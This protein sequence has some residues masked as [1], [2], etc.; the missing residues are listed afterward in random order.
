MFLHLF[1]FVSRL[2]LMV[3]CLFVS[4][5]V[6]LLPWSLLF[7]FCIVFFFAPNKPCHC[8]LPCSICYLFC[9]V[10]C[11]CKYLFGSSSLF[12]Y[13]ELYVLGSC[14]TLTSSLR[15]GLEGFGKQPLFK[16]SLCFA[17]CVLF[18]ILFLNLSASHFK[19][20]ST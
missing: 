10:V 6:C 17:L 4:V 19:C 13:P 7:S 11:K 16:L 5:C 20:Q 12:C 15:F 2:H 18:S 3:L 8:I 1:F 14:V 9:F